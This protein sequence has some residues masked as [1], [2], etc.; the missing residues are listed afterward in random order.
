MFGADRNQA[1]GGIRCDFSADSRTDAW[2][3][4]GSQGSVTLAAQ[5]GINCFG[6]GSTDV[7]EGPTYLANECDN[8]LFSNRA[9]FHRIEIYVRRIGGYWSEIGSIPNLRLC[10]ISKF[11][12]GQE[13]TVGSDTWKVFP[14]VSPGAGVGPG[15]PQTSGVLGYAYKKT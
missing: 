7:L 9:I 2:F 10:N 11:S 8:N 3:S 6:V 5:S 4:F 1:I 15:W 13:I 12:L 14:M